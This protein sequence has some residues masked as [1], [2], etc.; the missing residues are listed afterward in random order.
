VQPKFVI[1]LVVSILM[2]NC[3]SLVLGGE[4]TVDNCQILQTRVNRSKSDKAWVEQA[5]MKG[6]SCDV[7][8]TGEL[9][10]ILIPTFQQL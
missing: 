4:S 10:N 6:F 3:C 5:E 1:P 2:F 8:F 7:K 9:S